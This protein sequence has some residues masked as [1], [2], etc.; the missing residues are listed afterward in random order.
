MLGPSSRIT[1]APWCRVFHHSTE[2]LM[3]GRFTAPTSVRIDT[4]RAPRP[5]SSM[6]RHSARM[7]QYIRNSTSTEVSRASQTQ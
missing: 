4:A 5:G 6:A 1:E 7:P 2:Y 3:I